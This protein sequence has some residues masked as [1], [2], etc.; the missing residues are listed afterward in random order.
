MRISDWSSDVCSSDLGTI[1]TKA[2][3]HVAGTQVGAETRLADACTAFHT[4][5]LD[6]TRERLL[7]GVDG[8]AYMRFEND[9]KG[10]AATWPF[11]RPEFLILNVAVGGGG[12]QQGIDDTAFPSKIGRAS[13]RE[14]VCQYG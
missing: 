12:G 10:D 1:H 13:C 6:W 8:R 9:G 3:N 4:Y 7:I 11:D 5:Q 2:Y 14:R